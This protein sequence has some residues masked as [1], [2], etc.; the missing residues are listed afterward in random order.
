M[1]FNRNSTDCVLLVFCLQVGLN[2][3]TGASVVVTN[4]EGFTDHVVWNPG[5][6]GIRYGLWQNFACLESG[7]VARP[8]ILPPQHSWEG[9]MRL[10][11]RASI[12]RENNGA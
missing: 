3:G 2:V 9:I 11:V 12:K 10:E 1:V 4:I 5:K 6:A 8:I 7:R